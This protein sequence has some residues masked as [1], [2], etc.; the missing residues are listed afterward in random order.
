MPIDLATTQSMGYAFVNVSTM[1][2]AKR[3]ISDLNGRN[4]LDRVVSI[5]LTGIAE[6][7]QPAAG[8]EFG[9]LLKSFFTTLSST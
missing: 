6:A 4:L 3:A 2:E 5:Q 9:E 8:H 7:T 1:S